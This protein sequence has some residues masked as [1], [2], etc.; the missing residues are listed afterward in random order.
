MSFKLPIRSTE[1]VI[2]LLLDGKDY[3]DMKR[4]IKP[5]E[6]CT[7]GY[8]RYVQYNKNKDYVD[9]NMPYHVPLLGKIWRNQPD[10]E[11][12]LTQTINNYVRGYWTTL[13]LQRNENGDIIDVFCFESRNDAI[14]FKLKIMG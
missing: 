6:E 4:D 8:H 7:N 12:R 14:L 2:A 3:Q 9:A 13:P 10:T 11:R 5:L 1:A